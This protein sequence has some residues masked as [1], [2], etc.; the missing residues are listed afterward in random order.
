MGTILRP[1]PRLKTLYFLYLLLGILGGILPWYVPLVVFLPESTP[2]LTALV[3][4][5]V[6]P[7]ALWIP[8]YYDSLIYELRDE[9]I[10]CREGVWFRKISIVPYNR[11]TN[12]DIVQGPLSRLLNIYTVKV[13]T[14]GYSSQVARAEARLLGIENPE[15]VKSAILSKIKGVPP[16]AVETFEEVTL[17]DI[18][19][20]LV[21][22]R[23]LLSSYLSK[24][25]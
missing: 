10:E 8:R 4:A 13:Q 2:Y 14:A 18:L 11:I 3:L 5:I 24:Q 6:V 15:E 7:I 22:I 9:E 19:R 25:D 16:E 12:V 23:E 20:E 21:R 1:S 17:K